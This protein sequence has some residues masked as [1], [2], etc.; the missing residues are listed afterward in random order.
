MRQAFALVAVMWLGSGCVQTARYRIDPKEL[1][2]LDGFDAKNER[3]MLAAVPTTYMV[4][5][6]VVPGMTPLAQLVTDKPYR[7]IHSGGRAFDFN[8]GTSLAFLTS[9]GSTELRHWR[10]VNFTGGTLSAVSMKAADPQ[11]NAPATDLQGAVIEVPSLGR[12]F[13]TDG[14]VT[15][16]AGAA[17]ALGS[18]AFASANNTTGAIITASF[19]GS[20]GLTGAIFSLVSLGM[21]RHTD[22]DADGVTLGTLGPAKK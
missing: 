14:L 6:A 15:L 18:W 4:G 21:D 13:L 12:T 2:S 1:S 17:L 16:G 20:F 22:A 11:L 5:R 8:S 19:A 3:T 9:G 10:S 7:L